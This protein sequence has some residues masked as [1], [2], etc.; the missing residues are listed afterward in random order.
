M[1]QEHSFRIADFLLLV[2]M[3]DK[4]DADAL[5]LLTE[6]KEFRLPSWPVVKKAMRQA[7]ILDGRNIYDKKEL[8]E[9]GFEY[10]CIGK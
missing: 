8:E 1:T 4:M 3:A 10:Y 5:L 9:A 2:R 6:W 7:L